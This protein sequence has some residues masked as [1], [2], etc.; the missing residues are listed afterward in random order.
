MNEED[1]GIL[2]VKTVKW[3]IKNTMNKKNIPNIIPPNSLLNNIQS[4]TTLKTL[5][6]KYKVKW[7]YLIYEN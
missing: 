6:I 5:W 1:I 3:L 7:N 4:I 2:D